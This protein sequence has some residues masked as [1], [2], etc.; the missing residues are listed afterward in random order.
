[1]K[2]TFRIGTRGSALALWQATWVRDRLAAARPDLTLELVIIRTSGDKDRT[3][4]L[5]LLEGQG[6]FTREIEAALRDGRVDLAVHSLKDMPTVQPPGLAIVAVGPREDPRDVLVLRPGLTAEVD[7]EAVA[8]ASIPESLLPRGAVV[9]TSSLRRRAAILAARPDLQVHDLRGNLDTRLAKVRRGELDAAV[10][11]AAGILRLGA[12]PSGAV[13]LD[14]D[15]FPPAPGQG[16]V[17]IEAR[18]SDPETGLLASV[19]EDR[20]A[21]LAIMAERTFLNELH[22]GCRVP[23]AAFARVTGPERL[24][25]Q[26]MV[27]SPDGRQVIRVECERGVPVEGDRGTALALAEVLG[28]EAAIAARKQGAA[29]VLDAVREAI[30]LVAAAREPASTT[31]MAPAATAASTATVAKDSPA[32]GANNREKR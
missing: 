29:E 13:Y 28:L 12:W 15:A 21:L 9:G 5:P 4:P 23:V 26:G 18:E 16:V 32:P 2:T 30:G 25:V 7:R 19:L 10:L 11:A 6:A 3:T 22:G 24:H 14:P 20:R 31:T 8:V 27:A 17:A 1:M